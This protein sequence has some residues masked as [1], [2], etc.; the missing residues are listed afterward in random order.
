[1]TNLLNLPLFEDEVILPG[2]NFRPDETADADHAKAAI[3]IQKKQI[4]I[5]RLV[6]IQAGVQQA[7]FKNLEARLIIRLRQLESVEI[8]KALEKN[9]LA[10][11]NSVWAAH[12]GIVQFLQSYVD[13]PRQIQALE[14]EMKSLSQYVE[15]R[16]GRPGDEVQ[17]HLEE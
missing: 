5:Q 7:W 8:W 10:S 6:A 3:Q 11:I 14:N 2:E 9:D 4:L 15:T 1:M 12:S 16:S 13:L 17:K